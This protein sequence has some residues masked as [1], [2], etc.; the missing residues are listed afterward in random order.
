MMI[1][2]SST[3]ATFSLHRNADESTCSNEPLSEERDKWKDL[4]SIGLIATSLE[5]LHFFTL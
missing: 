3:D 2:T 1:N 5:E 4:I